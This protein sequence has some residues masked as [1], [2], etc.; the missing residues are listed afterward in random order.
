[1]PSPSVLILYNQPLLPEDHPDCDSE[2]TIVGIA[3]SMTAILQDAGFRIR[4]LGLEQDPTPLWAELKRRRPDAVFNLFE[5]NLDDS[6]TESYVAGLLQWS[7][8]PFTGSPMP[9]LA[10]C[11]RQDAAPSCCCAAPGCRPPRS[12]RSISC[13]CPPARWNG[14][15]LPSRPARTPASAFARTASA[16][17]RSSSTAGWAIC[18]KPTARCSS[19]SISP[20]GSST[21]RCLSCPRWSTCRPRRSSSPRTSPASGRS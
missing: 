16:P 5:G 10:L 11:A 4:Q 19:R 12:S 2:H 15:S 18:S 20:A 3:E 7:G 1:M 13:R 9:A 6:E 14:R 17:T 8:I 21:W